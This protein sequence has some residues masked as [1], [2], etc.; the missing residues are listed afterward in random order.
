MRGI[1]HVIHCATCKETEDSVIDIAVKGL[2][3]LLE[4]CRLSSSFQQM[5]VSPGLAVETAAELVNI[6]L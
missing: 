3:W 1:T 6:Q 5:Q 4:E 2:F